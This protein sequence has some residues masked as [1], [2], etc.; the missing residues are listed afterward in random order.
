MRWTKRTKETYEKRGWRPLDVGTS[1]RAA[2]E[3]IEEAEA[4]E[5][6]RV[7]AGESDV[8]DGS[9]YYRHRPRPQSVKR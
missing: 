4:V 5:G 7:V 3:A 1:R 2:N 8:E 9:R 6:R